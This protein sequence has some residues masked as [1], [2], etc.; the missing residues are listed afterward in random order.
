MTATLSGTSTICTGDAVDLNVIFNGTP[1]FDLVYTDGTTN[2]TEN[3]IAANSY[4]ISVSPTA[5]STYS[6]VSVTG[7]CAGTVSGSATVTVNQPPSAGTDATVSICE[8]ASPIDLFIN[9]GGNP[10]AGGTWSPPLSGNMYDPAVNTP[11]AYVYTVTGGGV[12]PDASATVTVTELP[13]ITVGTVSENCAADASSYTVSFPIS[14]GDPGSYQVSPASS[15]SITGGIFESNSIPAGTPYNFTV[16]DANGCNSEVVS[17]SVNCNCDVTA[18]LSGTSTICA[19][20]AADLNVIFNGTPPFDLVYTDGTTNFTENGIA[21]NSY[22]ISVSPTATSTY[23]LVSVT[24]ECAGTVSGSATVTVNG[25][26]VV[27][28]IT[29]VCDATGENYTLSFTISGGTPGTYQV[30]PAGSGVLTGNTFSVTLPAGTAYNF[31]VQDANA[32]TVTPVTGSY[33]CGCVSDAGT[34]PSGLVEFCLGETPEILPPYDYTTDGNDVVAYVLYEGTA[35]TISNI[36]SWSTGVIFTELEGLVQPEQT[37]Y[38]A[39]VVGNPAGTEVDMLHACTSISNGTPIM[40][41]ETPSAVISGY[42][43]VC[44]QETA[45]FTIDF[46]GPGPWTYVY[47]INGQNQAAQTSTSASTTITAG[48]SGTYSLIS[49]SNDHCTGSVSG[50]AQL[51]VNSLPTAVLT[52]P[53]VICENSGESL[54]VEMGGDGPYTFTYSINGTEQEPVTTSYSVYSIPVTEPGTYELTSISNENCSGTPEGS[55]DVSISPQPTASIAGGDEVCSGEAADFDITLTGN[56]PWTVQYAIDGVP[57]PPLQSDVPTVSFESTTGGSYT[58]YSI[59]DATCT[60]YSTGTAASLLVNPAPSVTLTPSL[61]A[62]CPEQE[63]SIDMDIAGTAP[64]TIT[65]SVNGVET[66]LTG[67]GNNHTLNFT[68]EQTL[69]INVVS[70]ED[71]SASGCVSQDTATTFVDV[72]EL[73]NAPVLEDMIVC[74]SDLP[75]HI[76]VPAAPGLTYTWNPGINLSSTEVANPQ[77]TNI[78]MSQSDGRSPQNFEYTV[79]ASNG[80]CESSSTATI[81][82]D[83]GPVVQFGFTPENPTTEDPAVQFINNSYNMFGSEMAYQWEFGTLEVTDEPAPYYVFPEGTARGYY[84]TLTAINL[85]TMCISEL[86]KVVKIDPEVLLYVPSAF[87][88]D[89]D[90]LNDLFFPV[91]QNIDKSEYKLQVFNRLGQLVFETEDVDGK[92]NGTMID[93]E[94]LAEPGVYVWLIQTKNK[95]NLKDIS[96]TG[97]VT[98][99]R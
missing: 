43:A 79:T 73:P 88:P 41:H 8:N 85:E 65:Y 23:S 63:V 55:V 36:I 1:P 76:G 46:T 70:I 6:L 49:V 40:L 51:V 9:L 84:V 10:T 86:T 95:E 82:I 64:F 28:N 71:N 80:F 3:G 52:G 87:T 67:V 26:P 99:I 61:N 54:N 30:L 5:T 13:L 57:Q 74:S 44:E 29:T 62:V 92:W 90:G 56:A 37:Y 14:G 21:A 97:T 39:R 72:S 32:C 4:N 27:S 60:G 22:N 94:Y 18:T 75:V 12:C 91:M 47:A 45:Q 78:S 66:T 77:L 15:G 93:S 17:G 48:T 2:F 50:T 11:G 31:T 89:E 68:P 20:D 53:S 33:N 7:V 34:M 98:L 83:P 38:I 59:S 69:L 35:T 25:S 16:S 81:T 58:I 96:R 19:G 24:G 42:A